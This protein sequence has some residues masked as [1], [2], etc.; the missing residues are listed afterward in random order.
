MVNHGHFKVNGRRVDIPSSRVKPG[1]VISIRDTAPSKALATRYLMEN[2]RYT[3]S[4][5][6]TVDLQELLVT[7]DRLP[8]RDEIPSPANEQLIVELYSK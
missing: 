1:D 5:W 4:Q 3:E 6:L 8:A 2:P 7:V